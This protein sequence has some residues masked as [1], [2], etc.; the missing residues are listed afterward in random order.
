[1]ALSAPCKRTVLNRRN[2]V[3]EGFEREDGLLEI[4]AQLIDVRGSEST[5][6]WRGALKP[7]EPLHNMSVRLVLSSDMVIREV[8]ATTD[9]APFPAC[10]DVPPNLQQLVG[11]RIARGFKRAARA[12]IGV[13]EGCTHLYALLD[14]IAATAMQTIAAAVRGDR[15]RE[16]FAPVPGADPSRPP[17][18]DSC[19]GYAADGPVV[20]RLW[21]L[22]YRP[23]S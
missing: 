21:P 6:P 3:C 14:V 15:S 2:V 23:R 11:L 19:R 20:E 18:I 1:M 10:R 17:L 16:V 12:R 5:N 4:D 7:G 8:E 9:S 22:H 13:P